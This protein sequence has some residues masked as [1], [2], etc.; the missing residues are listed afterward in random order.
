MMEKDAYK[1]VTPKQALEHPF[2]R[3]ANALLEDLLLE[4]EAVNPSRLL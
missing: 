1:R 3:D 2:L 4:Q